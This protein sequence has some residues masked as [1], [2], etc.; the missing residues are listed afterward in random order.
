MSKPRQG[1]WK[2][3]DG[4]SRHIVMPTVAEHRLFDW[5]EAGICSDHQLMVEDCCDDVPQGDLQTLAG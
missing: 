4:L 1:T 3:L 5:P 2:A